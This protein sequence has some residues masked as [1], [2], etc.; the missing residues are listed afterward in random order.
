M[1]RTGS[2]GLIPRAL[3]WRTKVLTLTAVGVQ[4]SLSHSYPDQFSSKIA[5]P[6]PSP[7][8]FYENDYYDGHHKKSTHTSRG[9]D[10]VDRIEA[11]S[12][13]SYLLDG[14]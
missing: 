5:N 2:S 8:G 14:F 7:S 4:Q 11:P 6:C 13:S 10:I 1:M 3:Q 9:V 12:D